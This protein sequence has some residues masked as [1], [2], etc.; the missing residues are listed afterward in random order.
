MARMHTRRRGRSGSKRLPAAEKP[1]WIQLSKAEVEDR[2]AKMHAEGLSTALIGLRLRDQFG[3]PSVRLLTGKSILQVLQAKGLKPEL[4]EDLG[5]LLKRSVRLQVH[6]K[7]NPEDE[8]N[9]RGLQLAEAKIRRL[10]DYYKRE[11]LL[12]ADWDYSVQSAELMAQ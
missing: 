10:A 8:H 4:P 12:R 3:V 11:G 2:I 5:A 6:L 1:A 9:R 7:T